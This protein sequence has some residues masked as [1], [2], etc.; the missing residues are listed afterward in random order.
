MF[1]IKKVKARIVEVVYCNRRESVFRDYYA[2]DLADRYSPYRYLGE[3][4][5]SQYDFNKWEHEDNLEDYSRHHVDYHTLRNEWTGEMELHREYVWFEIKLKIKYTVSNVTYE[6]E[7][8]IQPQTSTIREVK[9][10]YEKKNPE[11]IVDIVYR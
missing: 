11:R 3:R 2:E 8:D 7:I 9:V 4:W 5:S 1:N 10:Y 6:K